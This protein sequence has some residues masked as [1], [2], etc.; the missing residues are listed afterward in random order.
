MNNELPEIFIKDIEKAISIL[1]EIGFK[2]LFIFGSLV[3]NK[4]Y[5]KSDIDL[6]VKG[7]PDDKFFYAIGKLDM[8]LD[9]KVDLINLDKKSDFND[10]ILRSKEL[11]KIA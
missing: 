1:K 10:L 5:D 3:N 2:E 8:E 6:A 11:L 4:F 7:I 9:H